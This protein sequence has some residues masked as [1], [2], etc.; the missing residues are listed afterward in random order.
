MVFK[1]KFVGFD[2]SMY[3]SQDAQLREAA[4]MHHNNWR[5][6]APCITLYEV[7]DSQCRARY[8]RLCQTNRWDSAAD[9][10]EIGFK[11]SRKVKLWTPEMV[12]LSSIL[13]TSMI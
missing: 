1:L 10:V 9:E 7:T 4:K 11:A 13:R 3:L 5:K 6:V 8:K 12:F 2:V